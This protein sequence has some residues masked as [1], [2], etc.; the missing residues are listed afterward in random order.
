MTK[1]NNDDFDTQTALFRYQ[2]IVPV[3]NNTFTDR[4]AQENC[5]QSS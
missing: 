1:N 3:L 2:Q 4:S 5:V